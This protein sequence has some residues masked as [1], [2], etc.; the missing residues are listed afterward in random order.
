M[1]LK[2]ELFEDINHFLLKNKNG[3]I[4]YSIK[5]TRV[6]SRVK[7]YRGPSKAWPTAKTY[8]TGLQIRELL[9]IDYQH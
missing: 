7:F 8:L 3:S 2:V 1:M 9:F 5:S 4:R 6:C